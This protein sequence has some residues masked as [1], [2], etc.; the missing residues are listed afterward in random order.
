MVRV[1]GVREARERGDPDGARAAGERAD[2]Q[3]RRRCPVA[4][5]ERAADACGA[6]GR[7]LYGAIA[8]DLAHATERAHHCRQR[9]HM[10]DAAL[11]G[12]RVLLMNESAGKA[13]CEVGA[14]PLGSQLVGGAGA[15]RR[16]GGG[17]ELTDHA[18][19]L[20]CAEA[21]E[22]LEARTV[23][24]LALAVRQSEA[25]ARLREGD[26]FKQQRPERA[27][28]ALELSEPVACDEFLVRAGVEHPREQ[29]L[30]FGVLVD[31]ERDCISVAAPLLGLD[32]PP[33]VLGLEAER[34]DHRALEVAARPPVAALLRSRDPGDLRR[35]LDVEAVERLMV[36]PAPR[37]E[38]REAADDRGT[39][40]EQMRG[41]VV[42]VPATAPDGR[43]DQTAGS[44]CAR[45][46]RTR[47]GGCGLYAERGVRPLFPNWQEIRLLRWAYG[48]GIFS[49]I[50]PSSSGVRR[51]TP[52][53]VD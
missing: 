39:A 25:L 46:N 48:N 17:A 41:D 16:D 22:L 30:A 32:V 37:G 21:A 34:G 9:E 44:S 42:A 33:V 18:S 43:E 11:E 12:A 5:Q 15:Q 31:V 47:P 24:H 23:E 51:R 14:C 4:Q 50:R 13:A 27:H 40:I 19:R 3:Q 28:L 1:M 38:S 6:P 10:E 49:K 26:T 29:V 8:D 2:A 36:D 7:R 52:T 53:P 35:R 20:Q 45:A